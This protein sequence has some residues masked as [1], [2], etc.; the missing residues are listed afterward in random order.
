MESTSWE[1]SSST[2][3]S[4]TKTD[5]TTTTNYSG[6]NELLR[7]EIWLYRDSHIGPGSFKW[8]FSF[9]LPQNLPS[10][11]KG[12]Y[13]KIEYLLKATVDRNYRFLYESRANIV[14]FS[15]VYLHALSPYFDVSQS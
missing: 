8:P 4:T 7:N 14:V 13:G 5:E 9:N 3:N 6:H 10:S 12:I 1:E 2:Y 15:P 11:Y